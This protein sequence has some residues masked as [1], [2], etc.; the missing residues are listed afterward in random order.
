VKAL[1]QSGEIVVGPDLAERLPEARQLCPDAV[2]LGMLA[3]GRDNFMAGEQIEP[4]YLR[5]TSYKKAPPIR[6]IS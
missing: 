6:V 2:T 3:A 5:L 4:I 1:C